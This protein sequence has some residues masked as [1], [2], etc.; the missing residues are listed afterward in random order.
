MDINNNDISNL[1]SF[2]DTVIP[3]IDEMPSASEVISKEDLVWILENNIKYI[4][5]IKD[6]LSFVKKEPASRV[7]G[8]I[9]E[10]N[11][12]HRIEILN[13][14][15]SIMPVQFNLFIEVIYLLYYSKENVHEIIGWNSDELSDENKMKPFDKT[16]LEKVSKRE[17]FWK[18]V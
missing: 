9:Q 14:M 5:P 13:L 1:F 8:G 11:D 3:S 18:Q 2:V 16:I 6:F 17:P 12:D 15:Q 10:L 4:D 7:V